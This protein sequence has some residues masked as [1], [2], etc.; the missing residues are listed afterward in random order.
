MKAIYHATE[1]RR[2]LTKWLMDEEDWHFFMVTFTSTDRLQHRLWHVE[3]AVSAYYRRLDG[4]IGDILGRLDSSTHVIFLSDHGFTGLNS[5]F[6]MNQWL[7][8][9]GYL[10]ACLKTSRASNRR[11]LNPSLHRRNPGGRVRGFAQLLR[12]LPGYKDIGWKIDL[13]GTSAFWSFGNFPGVYVNLK[14]RYE[15]GIVPPEKYEGLRDTLISSLSEI[16]CPDGEPLFELVGRRE[17]IFDGPH[18]GRMPD[19]VCELRSHAVNLRKEL[20]V[21]HVYKKRRKP[22]SYHDPDGLFLAKGPGILANREVA[23]AR[24][25]DVAPLILFLMG[26]PQLSCMDGIAPQDILDTEHFGGREPSIIPAEDISFEMQ[27]QELSKEEQEAIR[28][29]LEALGYM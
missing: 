4:V 29:S 24:I 7:A 27:E 8:E 11:Y 22:G 9:K 10:K 28:R 6:F 19:I 5:S 3:D 15:W 23:G 17:D 26:L 21:P 18:V 12:L 13:G 1:N 2:L 14:S 25:Q 16:R 20:G